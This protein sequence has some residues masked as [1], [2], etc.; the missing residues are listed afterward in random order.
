MFRHWCFV[1]HSSFEL[2]HSSFLPAPAMHHPLVVAH[3]G[4]S[5]AAPENTLSAFRSALKLG[6]DGVELDYHHSADGV[7]VIIHDDTLDRT[8]NAVGLWKRNKVKVADCRVAQLQELDWGQWFGDGQFAGEPLP[9]LEAAIDLI[10][11]AGK[12][13][14]I[15]RKAGDAATLLALLSRKKQIKNSIV[16][17]FDWAFLAECHAIDAGLRL[18][19]LGEGPL[20]GEQLDKI[21]QIPAGYVGWNQKSL[22]APAIARVH[23]RGMRAW[24]WTVDDSARMREMTAAGINA[25]ATNDPARLLQVLADDS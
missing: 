6:V 21:A 4:N 24:T 3:R 1:I 15:E 19:A 16:M 13:C 23:D 20:K 14:V 22:D 9:T 18:V 11:G 25:I 10:G 2:R 12:L 8:T 7:P 5:S 17:A